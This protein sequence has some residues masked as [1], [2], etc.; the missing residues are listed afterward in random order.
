VF[1]RE[2]DVNRFGEM[3]NAV[4][5]LRYNKVFRAYLIEEIDTEIYS[6]P[7]IESLRTEIKRQAKRRD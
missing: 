3:G 1:A 6:D 7:I 5:V 4:W 2:E